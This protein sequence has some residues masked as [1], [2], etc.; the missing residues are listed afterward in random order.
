MIHLKENLIP[1][2]TTELKK[3][4][5]E[6]LKQHDFRTDYVEIAD[7]NTLEHIHEWDGHRKLVGLV[8]AFQQEVRLI[9]NML[10]N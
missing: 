4:A 1:G 3:E 5:Q 7:A 8:A 2:P 10:L 9:D 6:I